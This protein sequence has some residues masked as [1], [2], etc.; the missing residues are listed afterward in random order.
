[1][2]FRKACSTDIDRLAQ[3]RADML[4][5]KEAQRPQPLCTQVEENT[6]R[7][8]AEGFQTGTCVGWI[9]EENGTAVAMGCVNFFAL[10]P[11]DWCP[12]GRTAYI[13]NLYTAPERRRQG[14]AAQILK[15]LISEAKSRG[16][17][18]ILLNATDEGRPL[19]RQFGFD[20]SPTAMACYPFGILAGS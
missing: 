1:M 20:E 3:L 2:E 4:W 6:R 11:N 12:E 5:E 10:P 18:R 19:Y 9:A 13:G 17:Q 7:F 14:I 16:C 8:L 15:R